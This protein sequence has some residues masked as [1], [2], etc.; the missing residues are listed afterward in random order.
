MTSAPRNGQKTPYIV[1]GA[2]AIGA[3]V[4][5][6]FALTLQKDL[7]TFIVFVIV[8][9]AL[10]FIGVSLYGLFI[11]AWLQFAA[12]R[13]KQMDAQNQHERLM[14]ELR[15][16]YDRPQLNAPQPTRAIDEKF[17]DPARGIALQLLSATI[18]S[19]D[20]R[21]GPHGTQIITQADAGNIGIIADDWSEGVRY[22]RSN[23]DVITIEGKG[24]F[25]TKNKTISR[26]MADTAVMSLPKVTR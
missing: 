5:G 13:V 19:P 22:L 15:A 9:I 4:F 24:T 21:Y 17:T 16:K 12:M 20:K 8:L 18:E 3:I 11:K 7:G 25:T 2:I 14:F 6:L 1:I 26:V 10:C 23:Y